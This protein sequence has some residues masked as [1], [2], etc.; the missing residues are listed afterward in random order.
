MP[1]TGGLAALLR[2]LALQRRYQHDP[3][4]TAAAETCALVPWPVLGGPRPVCP[5]RRAPTDSVPRLVSGRGCSSP[6]GSDSPGRAEGRAHARAEPSPPAAHRARDVVEEPVGDGVPAPSGLGA[7]QN[8]WLP[9]AVLSGDEGSAHGLDPEQAEEPRAQMA[10][11]TPLTCFPSGRAS[12]RRRP[13]A[14]WGPAGR[15]LGPVHSLLPPLPRA[16]GAGGAFLEGA[17]PYLSR[18]GLC[19]RPTTPRGQP[20]G[21]HPSG[22]DKASGVQG[23]PTCLCS[24]WRTLAAPTNHVGTLPVSIYTPAGLSHR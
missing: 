4:P 14:S 5:A 6:A 19:P 13:G 15:S 21:E 11:P 23:A 16:G 24:A 7:Q 3:S 17:W 20:W 2:P 22:P 18:P 8:G 9:R 10:A 1:V 12:W